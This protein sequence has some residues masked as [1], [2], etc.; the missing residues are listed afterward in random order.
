M[1]KSA[2]G[3]PPARITF[4]VHKGKEYTVEKY[5]RSWGRELEVPVAVRNYP[6]LR[7][8]ARK[9]WKRLEQALRGWKVGALSGPPAPPGTPQIYVFTDVDRLAPT[10]LETAR[11]LRRRLA[12]DPDTAAILNHPSRSMRRFELL[13]TLH[14]RGINRFAVYRAEDDPRPGRWPVFVRDEGD[15]GGQSSLLATP[16]ELERELAARASR[17]GRLAGKV[18]IEFCDAAGE[19]GVIRKYGA[20]RV[21]ERIVARQIHFSRHWV[22]RFPDIREP[23]TAAEELAY[24]ET[25]PHRQELAEIFDLAHIDY[26]RVD[27]SVVGGCIQVWEINT[28]PMIL[29]PK[30]R[31]DPLRAA[32]HDAFGQAFN[33]AWR[34]L[35]A[36]RGSSAGRPASGAGPLPP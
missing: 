9:P 36:R 6:R 16:E 26:G 15:H 10:E 34:E 23:S 33:A 25:N 2:E 12:A 8:T 31:Q 1:P 30:D 7:S 17:D 21:G 20:F 13:C 22:V 29:I 19:D 5:L 32:A 4:L 14:Q 18:V 24:V 3:P 27:Y 11:S 35:A 28:N